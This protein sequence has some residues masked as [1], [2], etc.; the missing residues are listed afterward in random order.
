MPNPIPPG[1][2]TE[3]PVMTGRE[4]DHHYSSPPGRWHVGPAKIVGPA[5]C[6]PAFAELLED[7]HSSAP[8]IQPEEPEVMQIG[9]AVH[10]A[11]L[12]QTRR[13]GIGRLEGEISSRNG[14]D[15]AGLVF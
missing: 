6:R 4:L 12:N 2:E 11:E 9:T 7:I 3:E 13:N 14:Y 8:G 15:S 10:E 5:R 1:N